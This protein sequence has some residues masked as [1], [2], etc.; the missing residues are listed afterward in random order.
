[1][2]T[3]RFRRNRRRY[4]L[5]ILVCFCVLG[6]VLVGHGQTNRVSQLISQLKDPDSAKAL[7]Q[8]QGGA[9]KPYQ[10]VWLTGEQGRARAGVIVPTTGGI[11]IKGGA[12]VGVPDGRVWDLSTP[13]GFQNFALYVHGKMWAVVFPTGNSGDETIWAAS[14]FIPISTKID[15]QNVFSGG[16]KV[17]TQRVKGKVTGWLTTDTDGKLRL[18]PVE[19]FY[20]A[21]GTVVTSISGAGKGKE[22]TTITG[23]VLG[24]LDGKLA[25]GLVGTNETGQR[26]TY[27]LPEFEGVMNRGDH[28]YRGLVLPID[29][30]G[31][32]K[33]T[34]GTRSAAEQSARAMCAPYINTKVEDLESRRVPL[35]P[36]ECAGVLAWMRNSRV[37]TLYM[38][39]NANVV[40]KPE[41][42]G[43]AGLAWRFERDPLQNRPTAIA[44]DSEANGYV[45]S[46][47]AKL[48]KGDMR[49]AIADY[50]KAIQLKP[51]LANAYLYS[52]R[53]SARGAS[54]D[55]AGSISDS[56]KAIEINPRLTVAYDVRG[57]AEQA[58]GDRDGAIADFTKELEL[59]ASKNDKDLASVKL[60]VNYYGRG[61]IRAGKGDADGAIADCTMAIQL[62]PDYAEA[63]SSRSS[64]K[65]AQGDVDGANADRAKAI[66][67][68]PA[69]AQQQ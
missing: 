32:A 7:G 69:L 18:L 9:D 33:D 54:G 12:V 27:A 6:L 67:L 59:A 50:T 34:S 41:T 30:F 13:T 68:K 66:Q 39:R 1:M 51:D 5:A 35:P 42:T 53:G 26:V 10:L 47:D 56:T 16:S 23:T 40:A 3:R 31:F 11:E 4:A 21:T 60:A 38:P 17:G 28:V 44:L 58:M 55:L 46:G 49:G 43:N 8:T 14:I 19:G 25:L 15:A 57:T 37:E 63:Y 48:T 52:N 24:V 22:V 29:N 2:K 36:H 20:G 65:R 45:I 61:H 62:Y 64:L